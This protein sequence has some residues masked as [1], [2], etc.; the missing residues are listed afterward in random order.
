[1]IAF[2]LFIQKY[3]NLPDN[4]WELITKAFVRAEFLRNEMILNEGKICRY[5]YFLEEGLVRFYINHDGEELTTYFVDAPYCFTARESFRSNTPATESIHAIS[6]CVVW[7]TTPDKIQELSKIPSWLRFMRNFNHEVQV[8]TERLLI[9]G[10]TLS[11]EER[12]L[13]LLE[14]HPTVTERVPLKYLA[15]FLGIAPQSLSRIRKKYQKKAL[16]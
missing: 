5:F 15:G 14:T 9:A 4:E 8:Y 3:T 1:M 2:K 6:N 13:E 12:Y 11:S 16:N 7:R 10:K